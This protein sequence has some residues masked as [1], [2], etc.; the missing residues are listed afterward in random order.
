MQQFTDQEK[1]ELL[2]RFTEVSLAALIRA[3]CPTDGVAVKA[4]RIAYQ[5]IREIELV[6]EYKK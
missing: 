1:K 5:A 2:I 6:Q 3:H 4:G